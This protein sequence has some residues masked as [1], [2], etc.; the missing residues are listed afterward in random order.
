MDHTP[1]DRVASHLDRTS[2]SGEPGRREMEQPFASLAGKTAVVTGA[3]RGIGRQI[4]QELARAGASVIVHAGANRVGAERTAAQCRESGGEAHCLLGDVSDAVERRRLVDEAWSWRG[5]VDVWVNNA[6][7]DVLT[8]EPASWTFAEKLQKLW[9]VDVQGTIFLSRLVGERIR[10]EQRRGVILNVGWD[11]AEVGMA[12]ESGEMFAAT[13]GAIMAFTRSLARTL[14]PTIRVNCLAPGWIR[15]AWG[16]QASDYWQERAQREALLER[17]GVPDDV[18][19]MARFLASDE[20]AFV[21][22]QV[23]AINGGFRG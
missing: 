2:P 15:T 18:A 14:A 3:S 10:S 11:Q 21:T 23:V 4:A 22:G 17:W 9:E 12:G 7:A 5:G 8:G 20:A 16:E 6:G 1:S 19:K 13:K